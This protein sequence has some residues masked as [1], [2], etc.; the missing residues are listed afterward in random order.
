MSDENKNALLQD[1]LENRIS[2]TEACTRLGIH[3]T[4]LWKKCRKLR[5]EG[6]QGLVHKL[7]GRR[8]NRAKPDELRQ[9]ILNLWTEIGSNQSASVYAF[10]RRLKKALGV[11]VGYTT[12]RRWLK[13]RSS[14]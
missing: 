8:S 3:R 5:M 7:K 1:Y 11:T 9:A 12:L 13:D 6:P 2:M 14:S 10:Q 4:T